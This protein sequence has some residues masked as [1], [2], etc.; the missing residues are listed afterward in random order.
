MG[1]LTRVH[2]ITTSKSELMMMWLLEIKKQKDSEDQVLKFRAR[3]ANNGFD[4][5]FSF[6]SERDIEVR[7]LNKMVAGRAAA[8]GYHITVNV[9][10]INKRID[11][12]VNTNMENFAA[13]FEAAKDASSL[14]S[15]AR[16]LAK[17]QRVACFGAGEARAWDPTAVY[18]CHQVGVLTLCQQVERQC[19]QHGMNWNI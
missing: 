15:G 14:D 10:E 17:S 7:H 18:L 8:A 1:D 9:D 16:C 5:F 6:F 11:D 2:N 3:A 12:K 4:D 13:A 19:C